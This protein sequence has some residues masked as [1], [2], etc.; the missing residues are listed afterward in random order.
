MERLTVVA[1]I[2]AAGQSKRMGSVNK[3]LMEIDGV[4][5]VERV[6]AAVRT[7][8]VNEIIVVT[9]FESDLIEQC[10]SGYDI[11]FIR[12]EDYEAG[13]GS[14]LAVGAKAL[15]KEHFDCILVGLGDLPFLN[16]DAIGE[17]LEAFEQANGDRI[18]VPR[19]QG[20]RGHPV[21]FPI[22]YRRDLA[23]LKGDA[24]ARALIE[25]E[26][27]RVL[28]LDLADKGIIRDLDTKKSLDGLDLNGPSD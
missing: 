13:M 5:M 26:G 14:S 16:P 17:V 24:G 2:L 27:S 6:V 10:L 28:E 23:E 21:A 20:K 11:E 4:P 1:I 8:G 15:A 18:V 7:A 9:G 25:R 3:L 22:C 12:N 19:F